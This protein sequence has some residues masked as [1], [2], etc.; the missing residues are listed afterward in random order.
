MARIALTFEGV[1]SAED[2]NRI[3]TALMEMDGV[4]EAEVGRYGA[5]VEGRVRREALLRT[6][7]ALGY[8]AH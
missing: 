8:K 4:E 1:E 2:V 7:T 5:E 6:V 3:T